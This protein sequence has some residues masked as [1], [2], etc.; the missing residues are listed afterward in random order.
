[1][2]H[3][4]SFSAPPGFADT[5]WRWFAVHRD[6]L[7]YVQV[8]GGEPLLNARFRQ[9]AEELLTADPPPRFTFGLITNL[10]TPPARLREMLPLL[11]ALSERRRLRFGISQDSVGR[12]AEYIR[13]GLS[14]DRFADNLRMVL[15]ECPAADVQIAPTMSALNV[16]SIEELLAWLDELGADVELRPSIVD[17]PAFQSPLILPAE[18]RPY[19]ERAIRLLERNGRWP[20]MRVQLEGLVSNLGV[21]EDGRGDERRRAFHAYFAELDRRRGSSFPA[22]FPELQPFWERCAALS[23]TRPE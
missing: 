19:L 4:P 18:L 12:R 11:R 17:A 14:W 9:F 16:T 6:S 22:V 2:S 23:D 21:E 13:F 20:A 7:D 1:V 10:N 3:P 15:A 8:N 5:F